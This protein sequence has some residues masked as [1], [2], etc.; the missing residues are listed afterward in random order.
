MASAPPSATLNLGSSLETALAS[1]HPWVYRNHLPRHDLRSGDW[2]R[3]E[4]GRSVAYGLYDEDG[5]IGVRVFARDGV[6]DAAAIRGRVAD[7]LELRAPLAAAGHDAYRL[8]YGEGDFLPGIT[9]DRYGRFVIVKTYAAGVRRLLPDVAHEL[10][11]RLRLK[12]VLE[13]R[14]EGE[15]VPL[16]GETPPPRETVRE[17]GLRFAVDLYHGQK[18]GLFLDHRDNRQLVR[19]LAAS[20]SVLNLFAYTGGFSV[21]ALA[22]GATSALSVDVA[23]PALE[24]ADA[25][26]ALNGLPLERHSSRLADVFA[27]LPQLEERGERFGLVV[28]DPPSLARSAAQRRRALRA[29]HRLNRAALRLVEPGGYLATASCTAQIAPEAFAGVVAAAA[30]AAGVRAQVVVERGQP[31]DHPV[32]LSFPEGRY[33]K[34]LLVR[35]LPG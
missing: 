34:F 32:P 6:P 25:N 31:L 27:L 1:G 4:A 29:Y 2:V 33:L 3:L 8:L 14:G 13:R 23:A 19:E 35:V 7:A 15:L 22:G 10:A 5:A 12:G 16:W 28:L 17:H 9:A 21:Y 24:E 18:T 20:R 30:Q 11:A 26:V